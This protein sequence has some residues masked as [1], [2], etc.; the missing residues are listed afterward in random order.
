[1]IVYR[2]IEKCYKYGIDDKSRSEFYDYQ[3]GIISTP[4][5][6]H[7]DGMNTHNYQKGINYL[8]FFHFYEDV[9]QYISNMPSCYYGGGCYI[10]TYNIPDEILQKFIG[11][12]FY[13]EHLHSLIPVLEY[14]IPYSELKNEFIDGRTIQ[15][16]YDSTK[17]DEYKK[18]ILG[19]YNLYLDKI[20]EED[21]EFVKKMIR[22]RK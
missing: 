15:Y 5:K 11:F 19:G 8:H 6:S 9:I 13:P 22:I 12:G 21:K 14:A 1:M 17:S 2:M 3:N 16:H 10:A 7:N 18:Y 4:S 20:N